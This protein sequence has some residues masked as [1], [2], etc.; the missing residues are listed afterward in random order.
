M[1][2]RKH[3]FP[4]EGEIVFCT[5]TNVQYNSVFVKIEEYDKSGLIHISEISPGRIRNIRDY[6]R[7]GKMIVCKIIKV[8][9][10]SGNIDVSLRRV[11]EMQ[12]RQKTDERK[13]EQKAEKIIESLAEQ[14]K[15]P[16][17]EIYIEIADV[18]FKKYELIQQAFEDVVEKNQSLEKLGINKEYAKKLEELVRE[19]I[20]PKKVEIHGTIKIKTYSENGVERVKS[21]LIKV[22]KTSKNISIKYLGAGAYS[23]LVVAKEYKEAEK[24]LKEGLKILE[25]EFDQDKSSS[26]SFERK[27]KKD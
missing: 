8:D 13:Q 15:R 7:E 9:K 12:K 18:V 26:Y 21:V 20:K 17:K 23:I 14:I 2:F 24:I 3:G 11:T 5:V 10:H 16:V 22:E 19:K 6:V 27:D 1:F 25:D 4:E